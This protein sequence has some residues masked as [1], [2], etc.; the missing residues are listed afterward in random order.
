MGPMVALALAAD[1]PFFF[2]LFF[3]LSGHWRVFFHEWS[4]TE[5][6]PAGGM[7]SFGR[8]EWAQRVDSFN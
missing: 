8:K 7:V 3:F 2:P 4:L 6:F 1:E 5:V